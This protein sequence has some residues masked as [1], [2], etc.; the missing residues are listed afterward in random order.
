MKKKILIIG[1]DPNSINSEIIFKSWKKINN[2]T[3]KRL[4][5]VSNYNLIQDQLR[6]LK[7]SI[8]LKR[9]ASHKEN[10]KE[11]DLK[12][13]DVPIDYKNPFNVPKKNSSKFVLKSINL[14]HQLCIK[15]KDLV[16]LIN[17][18]IDKTLL[19]KKEMGVTEYL[20]SRCN[21]K[22]NSEVMLLR[23]SKISVVPITTHISLKQ[24][25]KSIKS[26]IIIKKIL[27]LNNW[28]KSKLKFKP[29]ICI[30]GLNPHN[31][32]L[33]DSS[34]EK[35]IIIPTI[36]YLRKKGL[37]VSG[38]VPAD[39]V[40]IKEYKKFDVI[41]GMYHDQILPSFKTLCKFDAIN[42]TLGLKYLRLSP[43][44]GVAKQ[45]I[46]KNKANPSSLIKC[47]KFINKF[48]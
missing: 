2:S 44:H 28:F 30:L 40:F 27:T 31:S 13:I 20:A 24:V 38:P 18:P 39:T 12:I 1:G 48:C 42:I 45:I 26:N 46:Y 7:F 25:P 14:A 11:N 21:I 10:L 16:G 34:E 8:K 47:I 19:N 22:D 36:K 29:R 23:G 32:E 9:V 17:C 15:N 6:K 41:V 37:L 43:D 33:R 35:K 3:K 4:Y 5:F